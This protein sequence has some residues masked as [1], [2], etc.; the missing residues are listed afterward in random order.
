MKRYS[1]LLFSRFGN[2]KTFRKLV[3]PKYSYPKKKHTIRHSQK[4]VSPK[5]SYIKKKI[6]NKGKKRGAISVKVKKKVI[7]K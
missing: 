5:Y 2:Q 7:L 3:S 1:T 6:A 4:L